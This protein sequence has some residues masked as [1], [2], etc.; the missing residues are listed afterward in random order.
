MKLSN[1]VVSRGELVVTDALTDA[2]GQAEVTLAASSD[3]IGAGIASVTVLGDDNDLLADSLNF[4]IQSADAVEEDVV[5]IGYFEAGTFVEGVLGVSGLNAE[6]NVVISA[7]ATLGLLVGLADELG[8]PIIGST[9]I[10]FISN[11]ASDGRAQP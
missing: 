1:L 4:E 10:T 11:C 2:N 6:D 9:P 5:R 3:D 7:G 8:E